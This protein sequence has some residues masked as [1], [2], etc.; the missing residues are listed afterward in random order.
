MTTFDDAVITAVTRHMND[1]HPA[2]NLTI[3]R[4][5]AEPTATA[6]RMTGLDAEFG[7]WTATVDGTERSVR[8]AWPNELTDRA[9]IRREVVTLQQTA[10]ERLGGDPVAH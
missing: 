4:A 7:D 8:I 1:D 5:F 2:D 9:S 10:T 3:V 6:A